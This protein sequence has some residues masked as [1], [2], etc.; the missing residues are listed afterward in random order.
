MKCS[1]GAAK[2]LKLP[3]KKN[4]EFTKQVTFKVSSQA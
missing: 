2:G 3:G 1:Q 4:E